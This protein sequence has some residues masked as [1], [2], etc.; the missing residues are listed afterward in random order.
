VQTI[1][2]VDTTPPDMTACPSDIAVCDGGAIGFDPPTALD[3]CDR[4][5]DV[6]CVRSDDLPLTEP[7]PVNETVIITCAATDSCDNVSSCSFEARVNPNPS[8]T[9]DDTSV[10]GLVRGTISSVTPPDRCVAWFRSE[11]TGWTANDDCRIEGSTFEVTYNVVQPASV[12]AEI[13][14]EIIDAEDCIS[15]CSKRIGSP[16]DCGI[17]DNLQ[18]VCDGQEAEFCVN[19]SGGVPPYSSSWT[20]PNGFTASAPCIDVSEHGDYTAVVTDGNGFPTQECTAHLDVN[21]IPT[22]D[23]DPDE[24]ICLGGQ[25]CATGGSADEEALYDIEWRDVANNVLNPGECVGLTEGEPCCYTPE[26]IGSF[27]AVVISEDG[28]PSEGCVGMVTYCP[29]EEY[30]SLTQGF[31]GNAGGQFNGMTTLELIQSLL[32][33]EPLV[34]GEDGRQ[35]TIP[36]ESAHCII[37]RLPGG[38]PSRALPNNLG[39]KVLGASTC[40]TNPRLPVFKNSGRFRNNLLSQTITLWL[41]VHL[42]PTLAD[43]TLL[44][45]FCTQAALAG[46]DGLLG[47]DDDLLDLG[48]DGVPGCQ[49][50]SHSDGTCEIFRDDPIGQYVVP[51]SVLSAMTGNTVGDLLDLAN[52]A[53]AGQS[54]D[55]ASLSQITQAI[56]AINDGFDECRWIVPCPDDC[57]AAP[58][59][60]PE[61]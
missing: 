25:L 29:T 1:A 53:L 42:D 11:D 44:G 52:R 49:L 35:L 60:C 33:S 47:T 27:T 38:G 2:V 3:N 6:V 30:C 41:N 48:S 55:D 54:T 5:V 20:G 50:I 21:D 45:M 16:M 37:D 28:C 56:G 57:P 8:C 32:A 9:I 18:D 58:D 13:T 26:G 61:P 31:Y 36:L 22:C 14:V 39:N 4:A 10:A 12:E 59:P 23:V 43:A 7:Y 34:V 24:M 40:Q 17:Q 46:D 51:G 15:Q 19:Y